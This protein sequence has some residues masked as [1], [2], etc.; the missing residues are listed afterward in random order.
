MASKPRSFMQCLGRHSWANE[1]MKAA[2]ELKPK[3][4]ST[5]Y[6]MHKDALEVREMV[7]SHFTHC[8]AALLI[9]DFLTSTWNRTVYINWDRGD[10]LFNTRGDALLSIMLNLASRKTRLGVELN[11]IDRKLDSVLVEINE[12]SKG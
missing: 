11:E 6:T 3:K 1:N 9:P 8:G 4:L 2:W 10:V 12:Q 5:V 7:F